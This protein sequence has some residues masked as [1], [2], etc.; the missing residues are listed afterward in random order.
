VD[1]K[2]WFTMI[3]FWSGTAAVAKTETRAA[4]RRDAPDL[5]FLNADDLSGQ[6]DALELAASVLR[7]RTPWRGKWS[8]GVTL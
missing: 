2:L 1:V 5:V 6:R 3:G 7:R 4:L 8:S